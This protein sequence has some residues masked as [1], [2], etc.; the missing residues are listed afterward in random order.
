L[1]PFASALL[2]LGALGLWSSRAE[3]ADRLA[4]L[5]LVEGDP[6]AADSLTEVV[7]AKLAET[8]GG[9]VGLRELRGR[10]A[11]DGSG[12]SIEACLA[13]TACLAKLGREAGADRALIGML[14]R[15]E[16][17][18]GAQSGAQSWALKLRLADLRTAATGASLERSLSS[19]TEPL[20]AGLTAAIDD[21]FRKTMAPPARPPQPAPAAPEPRPHDGPTSIGLASSSAPGPTPPPRATRTSTYV[22]VGLAGLAVVSLGAAIVLGHSASTDAVGSTRGEAQKDL[23][24]RKDQ[25]AVANGLFMAS[26]ALSAAA[27]GIVIWRWR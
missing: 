8:R 12:E 19:Q 25:A 23:E 1:R 16:A 2:A 20:I 22:I 14:S 4:V 13:E 18:S 17:Q 3:A 21:L 11:R 26:G 5:I 9:L 7:I 15:A 27:A 24:R 6:S 10:L